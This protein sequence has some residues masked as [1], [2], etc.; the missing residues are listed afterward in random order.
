MIAMDDIFAFVIISLVLVMMSLMIYEDV[1]HR[2]WKKSF[3][4]AF[5]EWS[6]EHDSQLSWKAYADLVSRLEKAHMGRKLSNRLI[7]ALKD[8]IIAVDDGEPEKLSGAYIGATE[9]LDLAEQND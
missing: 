6:D 9:I 7:L 4:D 1:M 5:L 8:F 2:T 3:F